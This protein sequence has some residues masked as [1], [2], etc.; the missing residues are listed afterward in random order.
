MVFG[1]AN[2][3]KDVFYY[4]ATETNKCSIVFPNTNREVVFIWNDES[5]YR[6]TAFLVIGGNS[7][8]NISANFNQQIEQ[9]AWHSK[10]GVYSG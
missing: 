10:Q 7:K 4:S 9:N 8:T 1:A 3:K 6:N 2:V 5:N